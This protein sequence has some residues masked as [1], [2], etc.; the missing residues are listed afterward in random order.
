MLSSNVSHSISCAVDIIGASFSSTCAIT[1]LLILPSPLISTTVCENKSGMSKSFKH[2]TIF[3]LSPDEYGISSTTALTFAPSKVILLAIMRPISPLPSM[4]T[5]LPGIY[6]S[7]FISFCA[8]PA[9]NIPAH[10]LP[11]TLMP[12][13]GRSLHPHA[14]ITA[15]ALYFKSP[16]DS[17]TAV[18]TLSPLTASTVVSSLYSISRLVTSSIYLC[19]YS[20]PV[21]SSLNVC[22]PKPLCIH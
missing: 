22:S 19:A 4:T 15:L 18:T 20:G 11:A 2:C 3:L 14:T 13:L 1:T 8:V 21:S 7:I 10:L 16:S 6:P 9:E 17:L 12:P 5:S